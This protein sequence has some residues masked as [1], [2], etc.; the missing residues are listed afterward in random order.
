MFLILGQMALAEDSAFA[1]TEKADDKFA[2]PESHLSAE[3]GGAWTTGNT[4]TYTLNGS[5]D[6]SHR[7]GRNRLMLDLGANVGASM[8]DGDADG[9]LSD[10][11][12]AAGRVET[13]RRYSADLRYDRFIGERDSLYVLGGAFVDRFAGYDTRV[14]GQ[15][16]YS[17]VLVESDKANLVAELGVDVAREDFVAGIDPNTA[18]VVAGR[19]LVGFTYKFN[20]SV[21]FSDTLEAYENVLV[22]ADLRV[23]NQAA[24]TAKLNATFSLKVSHQLAF[25]NVPVEGYRTL[26]QT[27]LATFVASIL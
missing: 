3:L 26:D 16:G 24:I 22:P 4:D 11:E 5:L 13:A 25:D 10:A 6:G 2:Q 15:I 17:R 20:E 27:T 9:L 23:L 21:A 14:H 8:V 12:R 19:G 18:V 1:G 7:W